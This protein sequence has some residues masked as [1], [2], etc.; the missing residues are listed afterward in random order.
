MQDNR[1]T[2][3]GAVI[4]EIK[5]DPASYTEPFL[6]AWG[7]P[8]CPVGTDTHVPRISVAFRRAAEE[9]RP[10]GVLL[11]HEFAA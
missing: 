7:I 1:T 9:R 2:S 4:D 6:H 3:A 11:G 5:D 10:V 8:F